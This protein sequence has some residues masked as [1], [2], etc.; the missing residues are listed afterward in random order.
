MNQM[1][2]YKPKRKDQK[3]CSRP[4]YTISKNATNRTNYD[5]DKKAKQ[6]LTYDYRRSLD[7]NYGCG[8]ADY[9]DAKVVEQNNRCEICGTKL[10]DKK[11]R[12]GLDHN[13]TTGQ[14]R[15]CLCKYCNIMV[16]AA[17]SPHFSAVVEY[18]RKYERQP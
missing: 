5:P 9:Y 6:Y 13:H 14:W 18:L 11:C 1:P 12:L 10:V 4:C 8:A 15:G 2:S 16:G 7:Y 17:E 3:F